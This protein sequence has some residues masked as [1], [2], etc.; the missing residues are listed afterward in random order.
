[1]E[2]FPRAIGA[3]RDLTDDASVVLI[4]NEIDLDDKEQTI[5]HE[6]YE[7]FAREHSWPLDFASA[8]TGIGV[9]EVFRQLCL[10]LTKQRRDK[11]TQEMLNARSST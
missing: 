10:Q 11:N 7:D 6:A 3:F 5:S 4:A 8:K 2:A 1:M 9:P